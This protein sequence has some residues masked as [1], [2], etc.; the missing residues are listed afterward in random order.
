MPQGKAAPARS[1]LRVDLPTGEAVPVI[2]VIPMH[3]PFFAVGSS[4]CDGRDAGGAGGTTEG[5]GLA[6]CC[7]ND[8]ARIARCHHHR[9]PL[10]RLH[11]LLRGYPAAAA[12]RIDVGNTHTVMNS[13]QYLEW[14]EK[15]YDVRE[16][17]DVFGAEDDEKPAVPGAARLPA[18]AN[19]IRQHADCQQPS[20]AHATMQIST[21]SPHSIR[22]LV[23]IGTR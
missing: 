16:T 7:L 1:Q 23:C 5:V 10:P 20:E 14:R 11:G 13:A 17:V 6:G 8:D 12:A 15:Q 21:G 19:H 22:H 3:V 4:F 9:T 18:P 2:A